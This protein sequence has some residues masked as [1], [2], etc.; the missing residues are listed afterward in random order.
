MSET[1]DWFWK[2]I[3]TESE[4]GSIE[5]RDCDINFLSWSDKGNPGLL[6][7][8]GH[9]AHAHWWDFI[10]PFFKDDF[11]TVALDLSGMGDSGARE[12]YS[13]SIRAL[14]IKGVLADAGLGGEVL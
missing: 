6:L 13:A 4:S 3:E 2:A 9:N 5:V 12:D 10:A 14:E 1:P 11:Q 8:H 7:V